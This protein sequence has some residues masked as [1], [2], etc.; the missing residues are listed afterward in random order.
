MSSTYQRRWACALVGLLLAP[1]VQVQ[2]QPRP[3]PAATQARVNQAI[4]RGVRFLN[5][6]QGPAG[7]WSGN[8]QHVVGYAALPGLTL[9]EC[10][11]SPLEASVVRAADLVR[12]NAGTLDTTYELALSILFLDR[13]GEQRDRPLIQMLA[14]RL[15]AGQ[16]PT[17]GWTYKCPVLSRRDQQDLLTTLGKLEEQPHFD[18]VALT[19]GWSDSSASAGSPGE[20]ASQP[21]SASPSEASGSPGLTGSISATSQGSPGTSGLTRGVSLG[22]PRF[23]WCIKMRE[24]FGG[25]G[26]PE[27]AKVG[28]DDKPKPPAKVVIPP[29]LRRLPIMV[30]PKWLVLQDPPDKG[31]VPIVGTTDNSNTQFATLALWAARRHGVPMKRSLNLLIFRFRTSQ[32]ANGS[33]GYPYRKGG[34]AGENPAMTC[35]G[36]LGLAVGHGVTYDKQEDPATVARR[37]RDPMLLNGL[38]A[39]SRAVGTPAGRLENLPQPNLY[40]LWSIERVGVLYNLP[41]IGG[42]EWYRWAAESLVANQQG[43]GNWTNGGYPGATPAIDTCLALLVLKRANLASDLT[44]QLKISPGELAGSVESRLTPKK[45]PE[46]PTLKT[47]TGAAIASGNS[48][49]ETRPGSPGQLGTGNGGLPDPQVPTVSPMNPMTPTTAP[50]TPSTASSS[51]ASESKGSSSGSEDLEG[52]GKKLWVVLLGVAGLLLLAAA[53]VVLM[54]NRNQEA[55]VAAAPRKKR[56][57][58][59]PGM[60]AKSRRG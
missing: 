14:A 55:A 13:L 32:N 57:P 29:R 16:S 49:S 59:P 52:G 31:H 39:L 41:T 10:G 30:D 9:L 23:G 7:T 44:E 28:T 54:M 45:E 40:M 25:S 48:G 42:K 1:A 56:P 38:V 46:K 15:I 5:A 26:T 3:L 19:G 34:G 20:K 4:D 21:G 22:A 11:E 36:L 35:V 27:D 24:N 33:W 37:Q 43:N 6:T 51:S 12:R 17:G 50:S 58:G 60:K 8:N 53:V 2:A 18:P 47:T